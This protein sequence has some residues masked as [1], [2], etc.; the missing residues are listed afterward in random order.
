MIKYVYQ[1][2]EYIVYK[3]KRSF[4]NLLFFDILA[5]RY[6]TKDTFYQGNN[7]MYNKVYFYRAYSR[8]TLS[9]CHSEDEWKH[10]GA[11]KETKNC[12]VDFVVDAIARCYAV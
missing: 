12:V 5:T 9:V 8:P 1:T 10:Q 2:V 3:M 4:S 7:N 11:T 6:L